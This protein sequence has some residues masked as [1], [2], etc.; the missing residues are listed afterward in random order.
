LAKLLLDDPAYFRQNA[1]VFGRQ[2]RSP[3]QWMVIPPE[4]QKPALVAG[5]I[6]DPLLMMTLIG[7]HRSPHHS[8]SQF[9]RITAFASHPR[10]HIPHHGRHHAGHHSWN[11]P[12]ALLS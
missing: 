11:N 3:L 12:S 1:P 5:K 8:P 4:Y 7:L 6:T 9:F 2:R 10:H